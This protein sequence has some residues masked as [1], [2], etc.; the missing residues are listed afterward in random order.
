MS[1]AIDT[2][3]DPL[4]PVAAGGL[5]PYTAADFITKALR[6]LSVIDQIEPAEPEMLSDGFD[7]LQ[8]MIDNWRTHRQLIVVSSPERHQ[9]VSAQSVYTIGEGGNFNQARPMRIE[10][11]SIIPV[12]GASPELELPFRRPLTLAEWQRIQIK[13]TPGPYPTALYYDQGFIN[14]LGKVY[15]VPVPNVGTV[16][17]ILYSPTP[18]EGFATLATRYIFPAGFA[19]AIRY[20]LAVELSANY[21]GSLTERVE[22]KALSSLGDIKRANYRPKDAEF[23]AALTGQASRRYDPYSDS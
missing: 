22:R 19:M 18:L 10:R 14:G 4:F 21:P 7:V 23:D 20:N 6:L 9:L 15:V 5:R 1:T 8:E 13:S 11:W 16:D 3:F 17:V 12:R 2:T